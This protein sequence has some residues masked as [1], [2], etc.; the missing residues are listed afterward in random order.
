VLA[1]GPLSEQVEIFEPSIAPGATHGQRR[2]P[3]AR[4]APMSGLSPTRIT[5]KTVW[6][7]GLCTFTLD[8]TAEFHAGQFFNL[9]LEF[10][11]TIIRRSYSAASAPGAPL[12]FFVSRVPAGKLTPGL[13]D[14]NEGDEVLLDT[15]ALGFFTLAEVPQC[16]HLWLVGTGTGLGP[17]ISMLRSGSLEER[18]EKVS[19][20]HGVRHERSLAYALELREHAGDQIDYLPVLSGPDQLP[21]DAVPG[22]ITKAFESGTLEEKVGSFDQDSHMLLCG[23]PNMISEMAD[24]LK[25]RGFEKHKRRKPGHFN[26]EKY[27]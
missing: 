6:A 23:N 1:D 14:K 16:K 20:I 22:R 27:W 21:E 18:F 4:R 25:A 24:L 3:M 2:V 17:Y 11:D 9:G 10:N 15:A 26:F 19:I 8:R 12:E 13:L 5:Q 7:D